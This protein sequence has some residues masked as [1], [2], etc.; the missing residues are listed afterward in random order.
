MV[1]GASLAITWSLFFRYWFRDGQLHKLDSLLLL[2]T[3]GAVLFA[4]AFVFR[5]V[6]AR[7]RTGPSTED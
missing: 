3:M 7:F 4:P 6:A 5:K 1:L 2:V